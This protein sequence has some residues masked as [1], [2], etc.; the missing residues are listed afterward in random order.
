MATQ[1]Y[2]SA[3]V[4]AAAARSLELIDLLG[5]SAETAPSLWALTA[6][7]H[8]VSHRAKARALAQRMVDA[9]ARERAA[10]LLP[11]ALTTLGNCL[12]MEGELESARDALTRA[13]AEY[14]PEVHGPRHSAPGLDARS[15]RV[16][17]GHDPVGAGPAER[18]AGTGG[19]RG[20]TS[21]STPTAPAWRLLPGAPDGDRQGALDTERR[22]KPP[23][24]LPAVHDAVAHTFRGGRCERWRGRALLGQL[25]G[26]P[27]SSSA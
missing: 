23:R 25:Q 1:G 20:R 27:G 12:W 8:S 19:W 14:Q 4:A 13:L 7:H 24:G 15:G 11:I 26:R 21:S 5:D 16:P 3:E 18:P 2:G 17:P 22:R 9:A 10:G 6:Y